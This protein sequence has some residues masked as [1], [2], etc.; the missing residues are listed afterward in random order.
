MRLVVH[1]EKRKVEDS[2]DS[3]NLEQIL[4]LLFAGK[5]NEKYCFEQK[6]KK[7][8][9]QFLELESHRYLADYR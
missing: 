4:L 3:E 7:W 9:P 2:E 1:L 5:Q 6:E 8:G